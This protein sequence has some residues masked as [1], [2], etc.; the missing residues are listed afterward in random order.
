MLNT[1]QHLQHITPLP[2]H[3]PPSNLKTLLQGH[4]FFIECD[5]HM[6]TYS[7]IPL[8]SP[9]PSVPSDRTNATP[10]SPSDGS[11][12]CYTV[13]DR[14]HALPAGLWDKD[15]ESTYEFINTAQGVF[16][17]IRSPLGVTME[18]VWAVR[19]IEGREGEWEMLE[20]VVIKCSRLLMGT[21]RGTCEAG[22][23]GIHE[24]MMCKLKE[25]HENGSST[26]ESS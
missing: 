24:K 8:P 6:I 26:Q 15:V 16:V 17:R 5:P 2:P 3:I 22:W 12:A 20:D 18:T 19:E 21:V 14:V 25:D 4:H 11:L 10:L 9:T 1:S 23:K 7:S 13:T